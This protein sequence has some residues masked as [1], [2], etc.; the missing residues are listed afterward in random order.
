MG[1]LSDDLPGPFHQLL[2]LVGSEISGGR[3]KQNAYG[4]SCL[5][6]HM[7]LIFLSFVL[8]P[9]PFIFFHVFEYFVMEVLDEAFGKSQVRPGV[10]DVGQ[11]FII[12]LHF[13][14]IPIGKW[15]DAQSPQHLFDIFI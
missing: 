4:L 9:M 5:V 8:A 10:K 11:Q 6:H 14:F 7:D 1:L 3:V 2:H 15:L 13:L 12:S